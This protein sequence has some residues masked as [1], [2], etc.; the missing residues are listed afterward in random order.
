[1]PSFDIV[2]EV[3]THELTNAVDQ[4]NRELQNRFDFKGVD[5][6]FELDKSTVREH[7][8][9]D[10]Q[11]DQMHDILRN[12]LPARNIDLRSME[13][14]EM[15]SNLAGVRR[16]I[17]FKQGIDQPAAKKMIAELKKSKLKVSA[18]INEDKL[19]VTGKKRDDLQA[20]MALLKKSQQDLPLQFNNFR[21]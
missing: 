6:G 4:A 2:S 21:D 12:K 13:L 9:S 14:G 15:Q 5:A 20:A 19:R 16:E 1:M 7:A 10:F 3:D 11:L 18:Q 17:T 8:P